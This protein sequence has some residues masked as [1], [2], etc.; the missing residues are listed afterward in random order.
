MTQGLYLYGIAGSGAQPFA[1][2][3]GVEGGVTV[4]GHGGLGAIVG[5]P[6][7][8]GLHELSREKAVRLLLG[9]QQVVEAAMSGGRCCR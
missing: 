9:H 6:P 4:L 7:A 5:A 1:D 2:V 8:G 3:H